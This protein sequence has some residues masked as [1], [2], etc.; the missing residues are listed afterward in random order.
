MDK[1]RGHVRVQAAAYWW[2]ARLRCRRSARDAVASSTSLDLSTYPIISAR[3]ARCFGRRAGSE[4]S[5]ATETRNCGGKSVGRQAK[6]CERPLICSAS[7]WSAA[8]SAARRSALDIG[9]FAEEEEGPPHE[10][11][12]AFGGATPRDKCR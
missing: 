8:L 3:N 7:C 2:G 12:T 11:Q 1:E 6:S 9:S 4:R 10:D 5:M